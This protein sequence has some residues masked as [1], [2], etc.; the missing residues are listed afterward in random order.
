MKKIIIV[1]TLHLVLS[2]SQV[3]WAQQEPA[4]SDLFESAYDDYKNLSSDYISNQKETIEILRKWR[5]SVL[6]ESYVERLDTIEKNLNLSNTNLIDSFDSF[7]KENGS[8]SLDDV[9]MLR[10][11][12]LNFEKA[13]LDFNSSMKKYQQ[14]LDLYSK[15]LIK[16]NPE[17]PT[18]NYNKT[19][20]IALNF[21]KNFKTSPLLDKAYYLLGFCNEEMDR[22]AAAIQYYEKIVQSYPNSPFFEEVV[23]RAA[24]YYF[25]NQKYDKSEA[26]YTKLVEVQSSYEYKALYKMAAAQF[27]KKNFTQSTRRFELLISKIEKLNSRTPE[28]D[29]LLDESYDYLAAILTQDF[30]TVVQ[31]KYKDEV[32]YRL[33][34]I[35]KK[36]LDEDS[37]MKVYAFAVTTQTKSPWIP[38]MYS[39]LIQAYDDDN[40]EE[41][42][43]FYRNKLIQILT[44]DSKWWYANDSYKLATFEAQDLLEFHLLK[45][46]QFYALKGY[47]S[48]NFDLLETART[49]YFNF[50]NKYSWSPYAER[51]KLE[52]ADIE[53]NLGRYVISSKYYFE[54]A[55]EAESASLREEAAYSLIWSESKKVKYDLSFSSSFSLVRANEKTAMSLQE[56]IFVQA[57]LYYATKVPRSSRRNKVLY[58]TAE[59]YASHG[60]LDLATQQ[61]NSIVSNLE[62]ADFTTV[63]A[64]RFLTDI[65]NIKNDWK[66][67]Q[68]VTELQKSTSYIPSVD[69]LDKDNVI[70]KNLEKL[71][72]AL[73]LELEGKYSAAAELLEIY[74]VQN[75][76]SS[77]VPMIWLKLAT[78][79][80][81]SN[82]L[83][84]AQDIIG[85]LEK[86]MYAAEALYLKAQLYSKQSLFDDAAKTFEDFGLK[87]SKHPW[88]EAASLNAISIRL[89]MRQ[90]AWVALYIQKSNLNQTSPHVFYIYLNALFEM[91]KYDD[92]IKFANNYDRKNSVDSSRLLNI[93]LKAYY[94]KDDFISLNKTCP[95]VKGLNDSKTKT[96]YLNFNLAFCQFVDLRSIVSLPETRLDQ[97]LRELNEI[98]AFKVD[99]VVVNAVNLILEMSDLKNNYKDQFLSYAQKGW[100]LAKLSPFEDSSRRLAKNYY[101]MFSKYPIHLGHLMNWR[102]SL[103][104]L[105]DYK[106]LN[107]PN[108][109]ALQ[110]SCGLN[111]VDCA[112]G[113][114]AILKESATAEVYE[115]L[116]LA[117]LNRGDDEDA[118]RVL[119]DYA[120]NLNWPQKA[121]DLYFALG[122]SK[123]IPSDKLKYEGQL[124]SP[125]GI[126]AVIE[127]SIE[128]KNSKDAL[129]FIKLNLSVNPQYPQTYARAAQLYYDKGYP[130]LAR[131][132][133]TNGFLN[134]QSPLLEALTYQLNAVTY[135]NI[136]IGQVEITQDLGPNRLYGLAFASLK[137]KDAKA[138]KYLTSALKGWSFY[139]ESLKASEAAYT[140]SQFDI[141]Q[142][143]A[144]YQTRWIRNLNQFSKVQNP[145]NY[146]NL[147]DIMDLG[148]KH[149]SMT[150]IDQITNF[151]APAGGL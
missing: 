45:S 96:A 48:N 139:Q 127:R 71:E 105:Y 104:E 18:P 144:S 27:S 35:Y 39:E 99:E 32:Y 116:I 146:E 93:I 40:N 5:K 14:N 143:S 81:K 74:V 150:E 91:K 31:D 102:M 97:I 84:K 68:V 4:A 63:K 85:K 69:D 137:N 1:G 41:L 42:V 78:L 9:L 23:W 55:N 86:S 29:V 110:T 30:K 73:N 138:F 77:A 26:L 66:S 60:E 126:M 17:A 61:L 64:Y 20:E 76:R 148:Y 101:Q 94:A 34:Q 67:V 50:I 112:S 114:E 128:D 10:L 88:F 115:N 22:N 53:Y 133:L 19:L 13:N 62:N 136:N 120:Q 118:T 65:Y 28:E 117:Y 7:I 6:T 134:T 132:V 142:N 123:K 125:L 130:E 46:A 121:V 3:G 113:L 140:Q 83:G 58:K 47:K 89:Q 82:Q 51:A 80:D 135:S 57:S 98:A 70:A 145:L 37:M 52:L 111:A 54:L 131:T 95:S 124:S 59:I 103:F 79:Y 108:W 106:P 38:R 8:N 119:K 11:A 149:P 16:I 24:D 90:Y 56:N 122:L 33:G 36:R 109:K 75:S 21:T 107:H 49:R 100:D 2:M 151:R 25:S 44:Q 72:T 43:N 12:Q 141:P 129:K 92:V 87:Y 15:G 147:R